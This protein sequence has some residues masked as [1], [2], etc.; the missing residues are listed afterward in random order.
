VI[1]LAAG[2]SKVIAKLVLC[3]SGSVVAI[4]ATLLFFPFSEAAIGM[5]DIGPV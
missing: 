2:L 1:R 5:R 4:I 3:F